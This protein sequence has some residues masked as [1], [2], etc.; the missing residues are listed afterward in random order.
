MELMAPVRQYSTSM[1]N[2]NDNYEL[3]TKLNWPCYDVIGF[4]G[5]GKEIIRGVPNHLVRTVIEEIKERNPDVGV[6][7]V[8]EIGINEIDAET[9]A[10]IGV[11]VH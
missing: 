9:L 8:A 3:V 1:C 11:G 4:D 7:G 2:L 6:I 10:L 5:K